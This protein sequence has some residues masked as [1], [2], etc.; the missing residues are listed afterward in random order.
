MEE[1]Q[2]DEEFSFPEEVLKGV[3]VC[4]IQ[5]RE[6]R[7]EGAFFGWISALDSIKS[8]ISFVLTNDELKMLQKKLLL[9]KNNI[10]FADGDSR[11]YNKLHFYNLNKQL[12]LIEIEII[13]LMHKYGL[14][15]PKRNDNVEEWKFKK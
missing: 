4:L 2:R 14:Y 5:A 11:R 7:R 9:A 3:N 15:F 10:D 6:C 12:D 1:K 8:A 13:K